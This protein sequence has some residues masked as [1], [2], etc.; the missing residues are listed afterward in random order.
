[1]WSHVIVHSSW[2]LSRVT[3]E[4]LEIRTTS[5]SSNYQLNLSLFSLS[6]PSPCCLPWLP[7]CCSPIWLLCSSTK[8]R[9]LRSGMCSISHSHILWFHLLVSVVVVS[10]GI[11]LWTETTLRTRRQSKWLAQVVSLEKNKSMYFKKFKL[12]FKMLPIHSNQTKSPSTYCTPRRIFLFLDWILDCMVHCT[13]TLG[14]KGS[15]RVS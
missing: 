14:F 1:M 7:S 9:F 15:E 8:A 12:C 4:T 13:F 5:L 2:G 6:G 11:S 10:A 3:F